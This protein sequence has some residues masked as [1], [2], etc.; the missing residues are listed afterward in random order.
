MSLGSANTLGAHSHG[1]STPGVGTGSPPQLT[2]LYAQAAAPQKEKAM[3]TQI[4]VKIQHE[5]E[6]I[7]FETKTNDTWF[8]ITD[9][10]NQLTITKVDKASNG[11]KVVGKFTSYLYYSAN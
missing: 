2:G 6:P 9:Y 1:W 3:Y 4:K 8:T 5:D 7:Y 10:G 11:H